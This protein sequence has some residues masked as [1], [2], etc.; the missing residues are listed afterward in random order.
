MVSDPERDKVMVQELLELK[1]KMDDIVAKAFQNHIKFYDMLR[2]SFESVIN[3]RQNKPAELI[4]MCAYPPLGGGGT[5]F[6]Y[7]LPPSFPPTAKYV[8]A[9][10][11]S[12]N[13]EW[14]DEE[15]DKLL[16]RV[17][18]LFRY[19]HGGCSLLPKPLPL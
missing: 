9:Q 18:V 14:S 4:G 5:N 16:D 15:L 3:R 7:P 13:K 19:I 10:L 2:E 1:T 6:E 8:D 17:M 12:G 11:K